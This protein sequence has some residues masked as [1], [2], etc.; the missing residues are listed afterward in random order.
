MLATSDVIAF[1]STTDLARARAFYETTLG[2]VVVDQNDYACVLDAH[3]TMLRVTAVEE[4]ARP[5]YTVLGWRV[6][7]L[8][9]AVIRLDSAGVELMRYEGMKQDAQGV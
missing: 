8:R 2:L 7:D 9:E 5:G 1:V 3:G 6:Q 4:V